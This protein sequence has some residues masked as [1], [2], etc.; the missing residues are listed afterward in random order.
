MCVSDKISEPQCLDAI[1][2]GLCDSDIWKLWAML[3]AA[4]KQAARTV[5]VTVVSPFHTVTGLKPSQWVC[6]LT[7]AQGQ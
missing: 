4:Q 1:S 3:S 2:V 7:S 6:G 5:I